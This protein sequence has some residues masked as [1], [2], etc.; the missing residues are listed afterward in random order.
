[1]DDAFQHDAYLIEQLIRPVV[2][3]Y[4]I[5]AVVPGMDPGPAVA[6]VRQK[7][8]A[9][10]EDIRFFRD[11]NE[12]EELFRIKARAVID[13]G[14]RYDVTS[15]TGERIGV[16]EH[17]FAKSLVRA[18]W[19]IL[20]AEEKEVARA[21]ES[22]VPIAILRRAIDFVPY[23]E[24]VPIPYHFT[25]LFGDR[26]AGILRR[27][28]ALR[29][30]YTIELPGDPTKDLDRRLAVALGVALDAFQGR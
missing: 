25:I 8:M 12:T 18:T 5:S 26:E 16:L 24:L 1:V 14:G 29:D 3:L 30:R 15:T 17:A 20:D 6:F 9:L 22:S 23:G 21:E 19:R 2:N 13:I 27:H 11:E 7:R 10:K 28:L 4:R